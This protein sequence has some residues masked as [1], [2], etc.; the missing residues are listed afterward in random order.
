[1]KGKERKV[2]PACAQ[3]GAELEVRQGQVLVTCAHCGS[4]LYVDRGRAV[5]HYRLART[6]DARAAGETLRR[7]MAGPA[8]ARDLDRRAEVDAPVLRY[9][10]V[11]RFRLA[12][13]PQ[14]EI[15]VEPATA[16]TLPLLRGLEVPPGELRPYD[17]QLAPYLVQPTVPY[18]DAAQRALAAHT[19]APGG[20]PPVIR[21]ASL[22]HLPLYFFDYRYRDRPY[23]AAVDAAGG[24]VLAGD[25]P[26]RREGPYRLTAAAVFAAFLL[27]ALLLYPL[28]LGTGGDLE[29][30]YGLRCGLQLLL[31]V[32]LFLGAWWVARRR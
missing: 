20:A 28:A 26:A 29:A 27:T 4:A 1:M 24:R 8:A 9:F 5:L 7:W 25:H 21:E 6:L 11:W 23:R 13:G 31:A 3:C 17:P 14:E 12:A 32:P 16:E 19:V 30:A 18:G 22:V 10:P 15:R 2:Q